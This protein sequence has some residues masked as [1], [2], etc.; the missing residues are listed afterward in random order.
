MMA[1]ANS[2]FEVTLNS[3]LMLVLKYPASSATPTPS[4]ATSTTP[5]GAK[6]VKMLTM[7]E[8]K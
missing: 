3:S 8:R 5:R 7:F 4:M 1:G 2:R 6:L